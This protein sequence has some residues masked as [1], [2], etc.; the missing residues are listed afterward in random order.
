MFKSSLALF[1]AAAVLTQQTDARACNEEE[2]AQINTFAEKHKDMSNICAADLEILSL[3][4]CVVD[5]DGKDVNLLQLFLKCDTN[6]GGACTAEE[7]KKIVTFERGTV[8][9]ECVAE[10]KKAPKAGCTDK[11]A[12]VKAAKEIKLLPTCNRRMKKI[13]KGA[14]TC[15]KAAA[16]KDSKDS[17]DKSSEDSKDKDSEESN[18]NDKSSASVS[19]LS[20]ALVLVSAV[21]FLM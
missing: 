3:P 5:A 9:K 16:D 20:A 18:D 17:N 19:V 1:S 8:A 12:C 4:N 11:P 2:V 21:A 14:E 13:Y 15:V 10:T 7:N 6:A